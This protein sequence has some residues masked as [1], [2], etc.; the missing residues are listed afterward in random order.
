M[1]TEALGPIGAV[2]GGLSTGASILQ[3]NAAAKS[4]KKTAAANEAAAAAA[5]KAAQDDINRRNARQPD[6][7]ALRSANSIG[8][9][10]GG[11]TLLTGAMGVAPGSLRLAQKTLLGQ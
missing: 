4:A 11:Q 8:Q 1:S 10:E 5:N 9:A 2:L 7:A 6:V 3:G